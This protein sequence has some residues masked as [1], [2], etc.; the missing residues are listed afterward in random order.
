MSLPGS[1]YGKTGEAS[2][3]VPMGVMMARLVDHGDCSRLVGFADPRPSPGFFHQ[4]NDSLFAEVS[5]FVS[6]K[7]YDTAQNF[8]SYQPAFLK[9]ASDFADTNEDGFA[10]RVQYHILKSGVHV[11]TLYI[12][13]AYRVFS[14]DG[15]FRVAVVGVPEVLGPDQV[16][17]ITKMR[18]ELPSKLFAQARN[19]YGVK[20]QSSDG[21]TGV[22]CTPE[23]DATCP[24]AG[25]IALAQTIAPSPL[26]GGLV[27]AQDLTGK[28]HDSSF[29]CQPI[30]GVN[31][32][33]CTFMPYFKRFNVLPEALEAVWYDEGEAPTP[34]W[35][36]ARAYSSLGNVI[37]A[38]PQECAASRVSALSQTPARLA[39][40]GE[41]DLD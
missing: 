36:V 28:L 35:L 12:S 4:L 22:W 6:A 38:S 40:W 37:S 7:G 34:D 10:L 15:F 9:A 32:G 21:K 19:K 41:G 8:A 31:P 26:V 11:E 30:S 16:Q 25:K 13:V 3:D 17:V 39:G 18:D 33:V 23:G 24:L 1:A 14:S 2:R 27:K 20:L 5:S 29:F